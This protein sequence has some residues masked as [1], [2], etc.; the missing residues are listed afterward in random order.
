VS[1]SFISTFYDPYRFTFEK[2]DYILEYGW[3][4]FSEIIHSNVTDVWCQQDVVEFPKR[5]VRP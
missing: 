2:S 5:M 1:D 4:H 3:I